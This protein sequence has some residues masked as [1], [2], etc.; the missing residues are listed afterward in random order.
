MLFCLVV[1]ALA[2]QLFAIRS[3]IIA[4]VAHQR[5]SVIR[6]ALPRLER[7]SIS[8]EALFVTGIGPLVDDPKV[9]KPIADRSIVARC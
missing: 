7:L 4:A 6:N 8:N 5:T 3:D 2:E 1:K 9:W